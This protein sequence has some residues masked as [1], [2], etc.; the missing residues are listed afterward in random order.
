MEA[1]E[2]SRE[3]TNGHLSMLPPVDMPILPM[4][5]MLGL[6]REI[7]KPQLVGHVWL[8]EARFNAKMQVNSMTAR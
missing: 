2:F 5:A 1:I 8:I 7:V 3:S 6:E 4:M